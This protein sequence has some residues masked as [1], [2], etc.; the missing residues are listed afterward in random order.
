MLF[1]TENINSDIL[2]S[3]FHGQF[4]QMNHFEIFEENLHHSLPYGYEVSFPQVLSV[5]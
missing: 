1:S 5:S 2:S 4:Q 3:H